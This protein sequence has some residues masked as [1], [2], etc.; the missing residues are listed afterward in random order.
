MTQFSFERMRGGGRVVEGTD[1]AREGRMTEND[2]TKEE[3]LRE[4][5]RL[6]T[7]LTELERVGAGRSREEEERKILSGVVEQTDDSVVITNRAGVIEYVNSAFERRTGFSR[8]EALGR[9]PRIVKSGKQ[10]AG[11][12]EQLW[13]TISAG[14]VF[15]GVLINQR[16]DGS[17]YYE[18]KTITPL[19]NEAGVITHYVS[20]GKDITS[21]MEAEEERKRLVEILEATTDLVAIA[22]VDGKMV[23]INGA[24]RKIF[25]IGP[26]DDFAKRNLR[27]V[28]PEW[29]RVLIW[30]EGIPSAIRNGSWSG[31]TAFIDS[32]GQELP[33]SQ[34]ILAHRSQ[35]GEVAF[36]STIARDISYRKAQLAGL[37]YL[38]MHDPLTD[39]PNRTLFFDRLNYTLLAAQR[40]K[41]SFGLLIVD[42]DR[43]K[44]IND[45][46]G[47][48]IGDMILQE[49]GLRLREALR[50]SD[51]VARIGGDEFA[52]ILPGVKLEGVLSAVRKIL[53]KFESPFNPEKHSLAVSASVGIALFPEQGQ[54]PERLMR[55]AD[56]AMYQAKKARS[57]YHVY[58]PGKEP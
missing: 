1:G 34:V 36:L 50:E 8:E 54:Q 57:G 10:E 2:P 47:H 12:Y 41:E 38:A 45:A 52:I 37:E 55:F 30:G 28:T 3:L 33:V 48:H 23:Y 13:K 9:N 51:T 32:L 44:E 16:K 18:E 42:V 5:E 24:G 53:K 56:Q 46:L 40:V 14:E 35:T 6:R 39:L 58:Q 29:A 19:K 31:E 22:D 25:G 7:R 26:G 20:T 49:V 27:E 11:F 15:R 4:V 17:L 43:F 21:R